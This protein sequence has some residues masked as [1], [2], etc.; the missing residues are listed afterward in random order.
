[1]N[2]TTIAEANAAHVR[3]ASKAVEVL[4]EMQAIGKWLLAE[5][6]KLGHGN[7]VPF[8]EKNLTFSIRSAQYYI[9]MW[10]ERALLKN[11]TVAFLKEGIR[12]TTK[13]KPTTKPVTKTAEPTA[14]PAPQTI[15]PT[16]VQSKPITGSG[17]ILDRDCNKEWRDNGISMHH[18][19]KAEGETF[20]YRTGAEIFHR[21]GKH[22]WYVEVKLT[23]HVIDALQG[24]LD[25]AEEK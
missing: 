8:V 16:E 6:A 13:K 21:N 14:K 20:R 3:I 12:A 9:K 15:Q 23:Q 18:Y 17:T 2:I 10:E 1:M 19:N 4:V 25:N 22:K 7:F 24:Y 5:K 11:A